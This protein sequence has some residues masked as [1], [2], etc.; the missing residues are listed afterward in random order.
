MIDVADVGDALFLE[1]GE[2]RVRDMLAMCDEVMGPGHRLLPDVVNV[3]V[4]ERIVG[5][6]KLPHSESP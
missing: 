3:W 6:P 1:P 4:A 2:Q 5:A